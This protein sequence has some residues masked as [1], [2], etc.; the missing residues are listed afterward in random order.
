MGDLLEFLLENGGSSI[1]YRVRREIL[2]EDRASSHMVAL[3]NEILSRPKVRKILAAQHDDGWIG[4]ELHGVHV[5]GLDSSV[6]YLLSSGVERDSP[7]MKSVAQALLADETQDK[8]YR[9]T[10]RGGDALDRG[11]RGGNTAVRAGVLADLGEADNALVQDELKTAIT[12]LRDS[13]S[14]NT[15]DDF[16]VTNKRGIRYYKENAHFPGANHLGLLSATQSWRTIENMELVKTSLPHCMRIMRGQSVSPT[17]KSGSHFVAPFNFNWHL[18]DFRI[19]DVNRDS[20][21]LVWWLRSLYGL[22]TLGGIMDIPE[23][24]KTYDYLYQLVVSKDILTK[25]TDQSLK[26]FREVLSI[27]DSWRSE[28]SVICDVFFHGMITL[29]RAGYDIKSM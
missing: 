20:Y 2:H 29:H 8:P 25:Q 26:R 7:P 23:F 6:S 5:Q 14:Y 13:L 19:E 4:N 11:G 12:Y 16:S 15:I 22:S 1:K 17:F 9:T 18:G 3:Q 24:R 10:F 21:A 27:E 28:K